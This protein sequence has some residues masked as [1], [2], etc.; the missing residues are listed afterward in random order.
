[1]PVVSI[2]SKQ[3]PSLLMGRLPRLKSRTRFV[4]N[5]IFRV[6]IYIMQCPGCPF[7]GLDLS[8]G[9][10]DFFAPESVGVLQGSWTFGGGAPAPAPSP[11]PAYTPPPPSTTTQ[12]PKPVFTPPTTTS[13]STSSAASSSTLSTL[14]STSNSTTAAAAAS[15]VASPPEISN[16]E[17]MYLALIQMG[18]IALTGGSG[19]IST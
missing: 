16:L 8:R 13:T 19:S 5:I 12:L 6:V 17:Q 9:L 1:M 2:V 7:A 4:P 11:T 14:V 10:F 18:G 15:S 3:S